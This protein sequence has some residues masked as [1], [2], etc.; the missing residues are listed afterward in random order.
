MSDRPLLDRL[1]IEERAQRRDYVL[2]RGHDRFTA[3]LRVLRAGK[4]MPI[5]PRRRFDWDWGWQDVGWLALKVA[6]LLA[7]AW[8]AMSFAVGVARPGGGGTGAVVPGQ[9]L[10][11]RL[12][13]FVDA[14]DA[15]MAAGSGSAL[16]LRIPAVP[17]SV[18]EPRPP[19]SRSAR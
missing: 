5:V 11:S 1:S 13:P 17:R 19:R 14:H 3:L 10:G 4:E 12:P 18:D 8:L 9:D 7:A 15:R 6:A 16:E 2:S